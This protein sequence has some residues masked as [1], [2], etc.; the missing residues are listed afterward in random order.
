MRA[1]FKCR[2]CGEKYTGCICGKN[3]AFEVMVNLVSTYK[4]MIPQAPNLVDL[5]SCKNG[6]IGLSDFLGFENDE[7]END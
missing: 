6:S 3:T 1:I 5:H 7:V 4:G 2:L